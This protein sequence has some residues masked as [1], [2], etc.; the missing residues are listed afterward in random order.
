M[1]LEGKPDVGWVLTLETAE[2][3]EALVTMALHVLGRVSEEALREDHRVQQLAGLIR[4]N[5]E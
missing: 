5:M 4:E 2:D 3:Q 1:K